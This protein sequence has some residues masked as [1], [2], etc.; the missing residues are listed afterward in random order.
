MPLF[1]VSDLECLCVKKLHLELQL[2]NSW[3]KFFC[4][5]VKQPVSNS[6]SLPHLCV[7]ERRP[8]TSQQW[9]ELIS[10]QQDSLEN[11]AWKVKPVLKCL[12]GQHENGP[13]LP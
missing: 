12:N 3:P 6:L 4:L 5:Q 1:V 11:Q 7:E 13:T 9:T 8:Q 10:E 2:P